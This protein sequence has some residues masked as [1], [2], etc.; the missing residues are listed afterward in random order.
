MAEPTRQVAD[1]AAPAEDEAAGAGR[2]RWLAGELA[3]RLGGPTRAVHL[4][5]RTRYDLD[6]ADLPAGPAL[7]KLGP[8]AHLEQE[9]RCLGRAR[10]LVGG[11][12]PR[13]LGFFETAGGS[14]SGSALLV[15]E[16]L[17]GAHLE[18][19][20]LTAA[21]WRRLVAALLRLHR[22]GDGG[23]P[24][25]FPLAPDF[26]TLSVRRDCYATLP[27]LRPLLAA[28]A[29]RAPGLDAPGALAL[30]DELG[31][32]FGAGRERFVRPSRFVH[33]DLWPENILT[34]GTRTW[35]VDWIGLKPGDYAVDL[36]NVKLVLDWVWPPWRAHLAFEALLARYRRVFADDTLLE[37]IRVLLPLVSLVHLVQFGQGGVD[38][39]ENVAAMRAALAVARRDRAVWIHPTPARR[40]LSA[41]AHPRRS[42]YGALDESWL[43]AGAR[44]ALARLRP[45]P[46]RALRDGWGGGA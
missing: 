41:L 8:V 36:A 37:R 43:R 32:E 5:R 22:Q 10:A 6:R 14:T 46:A 23:P 20:R 13:P 45:A 35:L 15:M 34:D 28:E 3:A 38:D 29:G 24:A 1:A 7:V 31:A 4:Q 21:G 26:V 39:P 12:A 27:Q 2:C 40:L 25:C 18:P 17:P 9:A 16:W 19:G 30:F 44:R 42:E 11:V 33:A